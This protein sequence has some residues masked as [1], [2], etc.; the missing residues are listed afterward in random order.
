MRVSLHRARR[1]AQQEGHLGYRQV[2]EI[3]D[4]QH[5]PLLPGQPGQRLPDQRPTTPAASSP[6]LPA[7]GTG[8]SRRHRARHQDRR[9][10][11]MIRRR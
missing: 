7:S 4:H 6:A 10:F 2:F 8:V 11:T 5:S 3:A 9:V 1:T